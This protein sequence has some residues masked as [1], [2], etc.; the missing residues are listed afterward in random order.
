MHSKR[1]KLQI[2]SCDILDEFDEF[3]LSTKRDID[4]K[5]N[6]FRREHESKSALKDYQFPHFTSEKNLH[7]QTVDSPV[8]SVLALGNF[9]SNAT[10]DSANQQ[11][12]VKSLSR[13]ATSTPGW[14]ILDEKT[15]Q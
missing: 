3:G 8:N 6:Q 10:S 2:V 13:K 9:I 15:N 12:K 4:E 11:E 7:S 5:F 14:S 1:K